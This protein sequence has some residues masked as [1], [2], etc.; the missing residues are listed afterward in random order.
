VNRHEFTIWAAVL[1]T[2]FAVGAGRVQAATYY[3]DS[4]AGSDANSGRTSRSAWRGLSTVNNHT[5]K[6][7][8]R[9]LF[10]AGGI[11][12]GK[13]NP[14]GSGAKGK[15]I[16]IDKYGTG[17]PPIIDGGGSTGDAV[18]Y[19]RNQQYWEV[20]NLEITNNASAQGDR[21]GVL[22]AAANCGLLRHIHLKNLHIH[23][24]KGI[25]GQDGKAKDTAGIA[26]FIE[27]DDAVDT[28]FDDVLIEGCTIN[29]ID[30]TGICT[31]SKAG[32]SNTPGEYNWNRRRFTNLRI[33]NNV[34]HDIAK[35]AMIIR[36]DDRGVVEH[37]VCYNTARSTTG[38]TIFTRSSRGTVLQ[39]NEGY[40]NK[41]PDNDG[42]LYDADLESPECVFQYSYSHDNNHGLFWM[43]TKPQDNDVIVRY[44]ISQNDK[45]IIFCMNY[46]NTSAYVYNNTVYIPPHLSPTIIGERRNAD[47]TYYFYNNIIYNLSPTAKYDW[48]NAKRTIDYNVFYGEH[49]ASEPSDPHKLTADPRLIAPG[50]AG[51]G[52]N[53]VNGYKLRPDSPC[54]DSGMTIP[55]NGGLDYWGNALPYNRTPD[56]GAH[57]YRPAASIKT[58]MPNTK[59]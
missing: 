34:I 28:R 27:A 56:R 49:P 9:I 6:P 45:G 38:N 18:F 42:S 39:Y 12:T 4:A 40:L 46:A 31:S 26:V 10:K 33:R 43:C 30:N 11:W 13:L 59:D 53:T 14:R 1:L 50:T 47:K 15:A 3:V 19:L 32:G 44:N 48:Y 35:N 5:F 23:H 52:L 21:R 41:S 36:L 25:V 24:I 7:G 8:D 20:N 54:I 58:P 57:E 2:F 17:N 22:I 51:I 16:V 37:N 29:T 55:G